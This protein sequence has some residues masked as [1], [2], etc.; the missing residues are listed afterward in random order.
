MIYKLNN[1]TMFEQQG[2]IC[3]PPIRKTFPRGTRVKDSAHPGSQNLARVVSVIGSDG[4][5]AIVVR[6]QL[7]RVS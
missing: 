2:V 4:F 7:T 5:V 6:Q 3:H 1:A